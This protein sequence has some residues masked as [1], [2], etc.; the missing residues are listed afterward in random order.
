MREYLLLQMESKAFSV[1]NYSV[2]CACSDG[3]RT[4]SA[5]RGSA[6]QSTLSGVHPAG[7]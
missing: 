2:T 6:V 5:D 1:L 3:A 4:C 7:V